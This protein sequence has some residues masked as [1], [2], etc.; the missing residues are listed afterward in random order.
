MLRF[1]GSQ[2]ALGIFC[3][4]TLWGDLILLDTFVNYIQK[5]DCQRVFRILC[6]LECFEYLAIIVALVNILQ[7]YNEYL[8]YFG[9]LNVLNILQAVVLV[10][11]SQ[12]DHCPTTVLNILQS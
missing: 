3:L 12:D 9:Y 1:N 7:G 11:Q 8:E 4:E 2:S 10:L 5:C 6:I